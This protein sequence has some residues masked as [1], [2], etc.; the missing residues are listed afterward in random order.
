M[1]TGVVDGEELTIHV[2]H[3]DSLAAELHRGALSRLQLTRVDGGSESPNSVTPPRRATGLTTRCCEPDVTPWGASAPAREPDAAFACLLCVPRQ[4]QACQ[5]RMGM[6]T[7]SMY[8]SN[9][10]VLC[11]P[12]DPDKSAT[13]FGAYR[14]LPMRYGVFTIDIDMVPIAVGLRTFCACPV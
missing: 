9:G 4:E 3:R 10:Y 1:H 6:T 8:L 5:G 7:V 12:S 13:S 2:E 14:R 11:W